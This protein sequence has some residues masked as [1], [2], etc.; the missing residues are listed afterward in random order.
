MG[1]SLIQTILEHSLVSAANY[2][3]AVANGKTTD[4][5][6][7]ADRMPESW[8]ASLLMQEFHRNGLAAFPEVRADHDFE[9]FESNGVSL[10][11]EGNLLG[12]AKIDL[13]VADTSKN[14]VMRFMAAIELKGPKSNWNQFQHDIERLKEIKKIVSS[15]DCSFVFAYI[16]CPLLNGEKQK[17][18]LALKEKT[19]IDLSQFKILSSLCDSVDTTGGARRSYI[20]IYYV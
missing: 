7:G 18:E 8:V 2:F 15:D 4:V 19:G 16:T 3:E 17:E 1:N 13:F 10:K 12:R 5:N 11:N 20:Y 9:Y 6:W 14:G